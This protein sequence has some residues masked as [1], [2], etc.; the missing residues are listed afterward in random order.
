MIKHK[1]A[2]EKKRR[3]I[4][5]KKEV[6]KKMRVL[7]PDFS[8]YVT[9]PE[10]ETAI[11]MLNTLLDCCRCDLCLKYG[12]EACGLIYL[13]GLSKSDEKMCLEVTSKAG[14]HDVV[15]KDN[16]SRYEFLV[17]YYTKQCKIY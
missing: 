13:E 5:R 4:K 7:T 12:C 10:V 15:L 3:Q 8:L 2:A 1:R 16:P 6:M 11:D 17:E 14:L 9:P